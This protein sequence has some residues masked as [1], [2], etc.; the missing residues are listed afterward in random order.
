M[1]TKSSSQNAS[2]AVVVGAGERGS[3]TWVAALAAHQ[4]HRTAMP[5]MKWVWWPAS[6]ATRARQDGKEKAEGE[7][8]RERVFLQQKKSTAKLTMDNRRCRSS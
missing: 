8:E 5:L 1:Q 7:R 2:C 3:S 6:H 4:K